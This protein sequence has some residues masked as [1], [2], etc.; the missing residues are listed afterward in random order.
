VR[1]VKRQGAR[2]ILED[3]NPELKALNAK[4]GVFNEINKAIA[5]RLVQIE[6]QPIVASKG[7]VAG[8]A[9]AAAGGVITEQF[10]GA[11]KFGLT[12]A[13]ISKLV[14][15]PRLQVALAKALSKA[16]L[17]IA[18]SGNIGAITSPAFQAG[19]I[20]QQQQTRITR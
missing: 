14:D 1:K 20:E 7:L 4:D 9:G 19:R 16:R 11:I 3:L 15:S 10:G 5:E 8:G 18:K 13:T 12:A 2:Q 6:R 17:T